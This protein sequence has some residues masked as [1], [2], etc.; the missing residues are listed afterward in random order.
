MPR[1]CSKR[2]TSRASTTSRRGI[3][4]HSQETTSEVWAFAATTK[5]ELHPPVAECCKLLLHFL[6]IHTCLTCIG[7]ETNFLFC[8]LVPSCRF[9]LPGASD[10]WHVICHFL[11]IPAQRF[12]K[13][14]SVFLWIL[15]KAQLSLCQKNFSIVGCSHLPKLFICPISQLMEKTNPP[16]PLRAGNANK[17]EGIWSIRSFILEQSRSFS[18]SVGYKNGLMDLETS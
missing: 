18:K 16:T 17:I 5:V 6:E 8:K 14:L 15:L 13:Q 9:P 11:P 3:D 1:K 12:P 7:F 4:V 2:R 10:K